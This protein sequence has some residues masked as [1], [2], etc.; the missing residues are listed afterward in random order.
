MTSKEM[1]VAQLHLLQQMSAVRG[2]PAHTRC[3]QDHSSPNDR[4]SLPRP[5]DAYLVEL[6]PDSSNPGYISASYVDVS[7]TTHQEVCVGAAQR[8]NDTPQHL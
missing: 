2:R 4:T 3:G 8:A 5:A 7:G 1:L 6:S